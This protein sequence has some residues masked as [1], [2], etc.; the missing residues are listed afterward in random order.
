MLY[1]TPSIFIQLTTANYLLQGKLQNGPKET[2]FK[3]SLEFRAKILYC[4][5]YF[6]LKFSFSILLLF[7]FVVMYLSKITNDS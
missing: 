1:F 5:L 3:N 4:Q 7:L 2:K 6:S